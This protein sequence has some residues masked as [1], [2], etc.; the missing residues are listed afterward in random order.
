MEAYKVCSFL[1]YI[2]VFSRRWWWF[3][4]MFDQLSRHLGIAGSGPNFLD[5]NV[6]GK[7]S[8]S[9][10]RKNSI[11]RLLITLL[12]KGKHNVWRGC[13]CFH[14]FYYNYLVFQPWFIVIFNRFSHKKRGLSFMKYF[15]E[16]STFPSR[17]VFQLSRRLPNKN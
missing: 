4:K 8:E 5:T 9:T 10:W 11:F 17:G 12:E 3:C 2:F 1:S 15:L 13:K 14:T 6:V 16:S 7:N